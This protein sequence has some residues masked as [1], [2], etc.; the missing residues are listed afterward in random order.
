MSNGKN[1]PILSG[2]N[3][4]AWKIRVQGY[5]MQH[6][7]YKYLADPNPPAD[8]IQ[9]AD[10]DDKR[11]KVAG[12]LDQC[13]GEQNHQQ[14]INKQNSEDPQAIWA[15]LVGYYKSSSVQNQSLV[16]QE[17]LALQ[18][19]TTIA[20]FLDELNT[21][22]SAL[23]AVGLI[24]GKPEK[25]DI[26]EYLLAKAV[27]AK[28][29]EQYQAV[30][31]ILYQQQPLTLK[32]IRDS[33]NSKHCEAA[34][35]TSSS[36]PTIKQESAL[37][38]KSQPGKPTGEKDFPR[39]SPGWHNPATTGDTEADC[40]MKRKPNT[41]N[42]C[43]STQKENVNLGW[44]KHIPNFTENAKA[45]LTPQ[46][47][48]DN[49][50]ASSISTAPNGF[51]CIRRALSAVQFKD[52]CFLDSGVSHRMFSDHARFTEYR[53]RQTLIELAD[54]NTLESIGEGHVHI[55]AKDNSTL[56][57]KAL[58]VPKLAGMLISFGQLYKRGC[59]VKCTGTKTFDLVKH[60][61]VILSAEVVGGTCNVK[62]RSH[63][64]GQSKSHL[65]PIA[66]KTTATDVNLLHRAAGHPSAK[67]LK[68]MF[69]LALVRN[70]KCVACA[71]SKSH[72]LP[73]PGTLPE[74]THPLEYV[75]M[76]L[77]GK[78]SPASFGG[79]QY[80]F[81]ITDHFTQFCYVYLLSSKSKTFSQFLK[82]YN[83]VTNKH[84]CN[85]K[86]VIFDGGGEFN[87]KEFLSFLS[88][89]GISV[90]VT[91]PYTPQH[92]AVAKQANWTT[93]KKARC[94]LKQANLPS[95][96]WGEAVNTAVFLENVTPVR[97]LK[98]K[99]P[100]QLWHGQPFDK[101]CLKPFGCLAF[102]NIPKPLRDGKFGDTSK[103]GLLV[104][105]QHGAHNWSVLLPGGKVERCHDVIFHEADFP[106]VSFVYETLYL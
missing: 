69:P 13:M 79:K 76:D 74:E 66:L 57:L 42:I 44:A 97:K 55:V 33:L 77:S 98:W 96:Y 105:Y 49:D 36:T 70:L 50:K 73:F 54:G 90:Q 58:H 45:A 83:E 99:T 43:D 1:L 20:A 92:N 53:I 23:A 9:R 86:T 100:Y 81:K 60:N 80:Y 2:N 75:S 15:L 12:I 102:A 14:F 91:A 7:L 56:K 103:R 39:C 84:T 16:Y 65:P 25:A 51:V 4:T 41:T 95:K 29:P 104:G 63:P 46:V 28:L 62:L 17:F 30:K 71:L 82:Y 101:S 93:S 32:I 87:S 52:T 27:V 61:S 72:Q 10:W 3:F 67:A 22:V 11:I 48:D 88:D 8:D 40:R 6:G 26:K 21:C 24:V 19:K 18:Y 64:Q 31:D 38:A 89:K 78:I 85:I 35:P 34:A 106:G 37:K 5:C 68:R 47:D 94:L 59:D